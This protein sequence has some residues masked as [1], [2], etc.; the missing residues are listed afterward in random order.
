MLDRRLRAAL[1]EYRVKFHEIVSEQIGQESTEQ[2]TI[3]NEIDDGRK[4]K[5]F[6]R[7]ERTTTAVEKQDKRK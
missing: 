2:A 1:H 6:S 5:L 3:L 4:R 7:N